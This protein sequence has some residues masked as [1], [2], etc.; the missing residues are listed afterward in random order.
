MLRSGST[1]IRGLIQT[2]AFSLALVPLRS[3]EGPLIF[4]G[5]DTKKFSGPLQ[6]LPVVDPPDFRFDYHQTQYWITIGEATARQADENITFLSFKA[7]QHSDVELSWLTPDLANTI[8]AHFGITH[9]GD[10]DYDWYIVPCGY[11]NMTGS[12]DLKFG[13]LAISVPYGDLI[14]QNDAIRDDLE[15]ECHLSVMPRNVTDDGRDLLAWSE[16]HGPPIHGVRP[17]E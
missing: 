6:R 14:I 4:G 3:E 2:R 13:D 10:D 8:A 7:M 16:H 11:K 5:V 15:G 12:L 17:G 1:T 9:M